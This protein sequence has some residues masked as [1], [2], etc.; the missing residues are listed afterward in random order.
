MSNRRHHAFTLVELLVVISIVALLVAML[1]PALKNAREQ[2]KR[3]LCQGNL[4]QTHLVVTDYSYDNHDWLP[5]PGYGYPAC[6]VNPGNYYLVPDPDISGSPNTIPVY[7][8]FGSGLDPNYVTS[9]KLW[10]CPSWDYQIDPAGNYAYW[11]SWLNDP[12]RGPNEITYEWLPFISGD[13]TQGG[14][15][16]IV[17]HFGVKTTDTF[18]TYSY[19]TS[20]A[21]SIIMHDCAAVLP[22]NPPRYPAINHVNGSSGGMSQVSGLPL[23][24]ELAGGNALHGDGQI[25]WVDAAAPSTFG[26]TR[27]YTQIDYPD[28]W[29]YAIC[30]DK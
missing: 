4:R 16:N 5:F 13:I 21:R 9:P 29:W 15:S 17:G 3:V 23:F 14:V 30:R 6:N 7:M 1:L 26:G 24:S 10:L 11:Y 19:V 28:D 20:V 18:S 25:E 2:A 27:W 22:T 12:S 8:N